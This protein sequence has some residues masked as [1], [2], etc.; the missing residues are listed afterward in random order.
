M[1]RAARGPAREMEITFREG[2]CDGKLLGAPHDRALVDGSARARHRASSP[3]P[4]AEE[5]TPRRFPHHVARQQ[6]LALGLRNAGRWVARRHESLIAWARRDGGA[7]KR[8]RS[9][10]GPPRARQSRTAAIGRGAFHRRPAARELL[11]VRVWRRRH[12]RA[13]PARVCAPQDQQRHLPAAHVCHGK[14]GVPHRAGRGRG[15][16]AWP[17]LGWIV[18]AQDRR[19]RPGRARPRVAARLHHARGQHHH[20][21]AWGSVARLLRGPLCARGR[22]HRF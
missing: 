13:P 2:K 10:R 21:A 19:H 16:A 14:A 1:A 17:W 18:G 15:A 3:Q 20:W 22:R 4:S 8:L 9:A 6:R 7:C 11:V 5:S 12:A